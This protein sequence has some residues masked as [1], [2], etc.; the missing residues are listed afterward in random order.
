MPT[1]TGQELIKSKPEIQKLNELWRTIDTNWLRDYYSGQL[2]ARNLYEAR[3]N[4]F[5]ATSR[6]GAERVQREVR[7]GHFIVASLSPKKLRLIS[8]VIQKLDG[9]A[10]PT[11]FVDEESQKEYALFAAKRWGREVYPLT[12][13][14]GKLSDISSQAFENGK[15]IISADSVVI[16]PKG[17]IL[18]KPKNLDD[19]KRTLKLIGGEKVKVLVGVNALVPLRYGLAAVRL[20]EGAEIEVKIRELS[21]RQIEE[22]IETNGEEAIEIAGGVDFSSAQ[23]QKLV[24]TAHRIRVRP[25]GQTVY[26]I[27][28]KAHGIRR[29]PKI[30]DPRNIDELSDYFQGAPKDIISVIMQQAKDF[31]E[32]VE[33]L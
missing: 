10:E 25:L 27:Y 26:D 13:A 24:D 31:Q 7:P 17:Q 18:E 14:A 33:R 30:I 5:M 21:D 2:R 12:I 8:E 1:D 15:T 16:G 23:G 19:L 9:V 32:K 3:E 28:A 4:P 22:Y 6:F 11:A 29:T 20:D